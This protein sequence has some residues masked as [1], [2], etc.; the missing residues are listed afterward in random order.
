[1]QRLLQGVLLTG[2]LAG[3]F[4]QEVAAQPV[5]GGAS[6]VDPQKVF[7]GFTLIT[8]QDF[9]LPA[10]NEDRNYTMGVGFGFA[11][12]LGYDVDAV[13][14]PWR[15][16]ALVP[17][18]R[19]A[20]DRTFPGLAW[21]S[22]WL[23]DRTGISEYSWTFGTTAFTP[24]ELAN[25]DPIFD[26]RPYGSLLFLSS[27]RIR[28]DRNERWAISSD[29]TL[30]ML[31]LDIA[32]EVQ[33]WIHE[34]IGADIPRG[35]RHQISE[36]GEPTAMYTF[37]YQRLPRLFNDRFQSDGARME[38]TW[39][40]LGQLGYYVA[41]E[42][43]LSLRAGWYQSRFWQWASNP[44]NSQNEAVGDPEEDRELFA[45]GALRGRAVRHHSLVE[46]QFSTSTVTVEAEPWVL[47]GE[48]GVSG[49]ILVKGRRVGLT[50]VMV[51]A[52]SPEF[53]DAG[54]PRSHWWGS[55]FATIRFGG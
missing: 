52:R 8:E 3:P 12:E 19:E 46:G 48:A 13:F 36:G 9:L 45:F 30:G 35:W 1:M 23:D 55:A 40:T 10:R 47:E 17:L 41:A 14:N 29:L 31:G 2:L 24:D 28:V 4:S 53:K 43:G 32:E 39:H 5:V 6:G 42:G 21:T 37:K 18:L 26:D 20:M 25:P 54:E 51:A 50:W 44:L 33:T 49:S 11:G 15:V 16:T 22:N 38:W 27:R 7:S 34:R